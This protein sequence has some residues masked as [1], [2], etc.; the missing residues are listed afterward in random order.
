MGKLANA[1]VFYVVAQVTHSPVLKLEALVAELQDRLRKEGFPGYRSLGQVQL[2]FEAGAVPSDSKVNQTQITQH[3]FSTRDGSGSFVIGPG[4]VAYQ[5][6][7]YDTSEVFA[8]T[9]ARGIRA[10]Q[11]VLAPD[12]FSRIG[13]RFLDAVTPLPDKGPEYYIRQEF[14]GSQQTFSDDW[15]CLYTFAESSLVK[16]DQSTRV[17]VLTRSGGLTWPLDLEPTAPVMPTK[18]LEIVG[19]HTLIDTDTSFMAAPEAAQEFDENLILARLRS[20]K[21]DIRVAFHSVVTQEALED[22]K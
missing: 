10:V 14:L 11:Q 4:S 21:A 22:W 5:T 7:S 18:F 3:V 1:P 6:V 2:Q 15:T 9:F 8:D 17:R 13:M 19:V 20:L 16:D 12:S